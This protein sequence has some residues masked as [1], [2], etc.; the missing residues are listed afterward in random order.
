MDEEKHN[1]Q[2]RNRYNENPQVRK[3]KAEYYK[4]YMAR[5]EVRAKKLAYQK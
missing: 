4:E 2:I 1:Q 3:Q 5:P